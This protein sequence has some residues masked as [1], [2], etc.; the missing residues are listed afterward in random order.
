MPFR[1]KRSDFRWPPV[2][3]N[4]M[5]VTLSFFDTRVDGTATLTLTAREPLSTLELDACDIEIDAVAL[6][7][8]EKSS[9]GGSDFLPCEFAL[10]AARRKLVI[11]LPRPLAIGETLRVFA[12]CRCA[13][14]ASLLEGLYRDTT[15]P[16][17]PQQYM[18]Q[19][20]QWG[21]QRILPV[22]DVCTAKCTFR[23]TL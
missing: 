23:T 15:P 18:S 13:P 19:C 11:P 10:D 14:S 16:G 17:A 1:Y 22:I 2:Q 8:A 21:F 12:R 20:Q 9:R 5:E 4:H 3:L 6:S 7:P